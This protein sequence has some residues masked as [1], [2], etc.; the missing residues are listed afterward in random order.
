M[1]CSL[2]TS[3]PLHET[4]DIAVNKIF[5]SDPNIK[6]SKLQLK[7]LFI[8]ATSQTH[9]LFNGEIFDQIDGVAMG[10]PLGPALANL[11]MGQRN[12]K[13]W[14]DSFSGKSVKYYRRYVDDIFCLFENEIDVEAFLL[15][16]NKQHKNIKF[17]IEK[18]KEKKLPFL[19]VLTRHNGNKFETSMYR[20]N[21]F[22]GL[23]MNFHSFTPSSYKKGL[24]KTLVDRVFRI[25]SS[26]IGFDKDIKTLEKILQKNEYLPRQINKIVMNYLNSKFEKSEKDQG[27]NN[28]NRRYYKLPYVGSFSTLTLKKLNNIVKKYCSPNIDIKLI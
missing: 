18:E 24:I 11:F 26:W 5:E 28:S 14:L 17:T 2:F 16:L 9:F 20:K 19:D 13:K 23:L 3:I 10:S 15:F 27:T 7:K 8:F 21:T 25:N 4:I 6:I 12:E 1:F 22:T